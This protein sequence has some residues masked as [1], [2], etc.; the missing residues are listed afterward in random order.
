M[1]FTKKQQDFIKQC[2]EHFE[3]LTGGRGHSKTKEVIED[4]QKEIVRLKSNE[5]TLADLLDKEQKKNKKAIEYIKDYEK[6]IEEG[7]K[8]GA[9]YT[10][11]GSPLNKINKLL[12]ILKG[13][14]E[15]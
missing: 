8:K 11:L 14:D 7:I 1:K 4:M 3:V 6:T 5:K 9:E 13:E 2:G 12:K 10:Y 15:E